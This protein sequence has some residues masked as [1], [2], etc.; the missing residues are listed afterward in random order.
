MICDLPTAT[1]Y[2]LMLKFNRAMTPAVVL[3]CAESDDEME[4]LEKYFGHQEQDLIV[5]QC[6]SSSFGDFGV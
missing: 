3:G 1:V 6:S 4:L 2:F 5:N